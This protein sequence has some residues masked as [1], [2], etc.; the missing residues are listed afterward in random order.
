MMDST[1]RAVESIRCSFFYGTIVVYLNYYIDDSCFLNCTQMIVIGY[2][3]KLSIKTILITTLYE[4]VRHV[5]INVI[6]K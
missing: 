4:K 5:K 6:Y 1:S 2:D 3:I